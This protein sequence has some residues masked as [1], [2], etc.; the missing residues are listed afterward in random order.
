[1]VLKIHRQLARIREALRHGPEPRRCVHI[2]ARRGNKVLHPPECAVVIAVTIAVCRC[3]CPCKAGARVP[4]AEGAHAEFF[5]AA[6]HSGLSCT[7]GGKSREREE[8]ATQAAAPGMRTQT[9]VL[10]LVHIQ[11]QALWDGV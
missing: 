2:D 11:G 10:R 3:L 7:S 9:Q 4:L 5:A 8:I 6:R 1:M